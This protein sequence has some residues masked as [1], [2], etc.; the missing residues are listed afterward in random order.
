MDVSVIIINYNTQELTLESIESVYKFTKD[1]QFEIIVVDNASREPISDAV[2][3]SFPDVILIENKENVGFGRANNEGIK[4]ATGEFIFLLNSDA[5]LTSNALYEFCNFMRKESNQKVGICGGELFSNRNNNT[6]SYGNFPSLLDAFS[7][8]GFFK[9]YPKYHYKHIASGI[10]NS[11][12]NIREVGYVCGA[13][14]LVRKSV[15]DQFGAFDP[16]FFL[17]FEETE[18]SFRF[19]QKG[20]SSFI[21]P[22]VKIIHL[23]SASQLVKQSFNYI[24]FFHYC[25]GRNLYFTKCHGRIYAFLIKICYSLTE[26]SVRLYGKK[27]GNLFKKL[28]L[29]LFAA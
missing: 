27:N 13:A 19:K 18:L 17:Y 9:L 22:Y 12:Q 6:V 1:I 11:D 10:V 25:R 16:D 29:I 2:T 20:Y 7:S 8:I 26:I 4:I 5:F 23:G 15:I 24:N 28:K 3:S 14:M 21:L